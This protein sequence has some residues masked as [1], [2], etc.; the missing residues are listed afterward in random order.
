MKL[1]ENENIVSLKKNGF[2]NVKNFFEEEEILNLSKEIDRIYPNE[3]INSKQ[4][5]DSKKE[6]KTESDLNQDKF[7]YLINGSDNNGTFGAPI[8]GCSEL[9]DNFMQK[10]FNNL[11]F[12]KVPSKKFPIHRILKLLPKSD[13]L[14][15]TV[16]VSANDTLVDLF[17]T[18]KISYNDIHFFLNKILTLKEFQ[19][20]KSKVP[21]NINEIL[22]LNEYVRLKTLSLSVV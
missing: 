20:Y 1:I 5:E 10:L 3:T 8:L 9:I 15:E 2:T 7:N 17:L 22:S 12:Q 14:F 13:S 11:N 18:K 19:K 6:K 4:S 16:L 21:K